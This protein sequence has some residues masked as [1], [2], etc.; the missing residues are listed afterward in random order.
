[1]HADPDVGRKNFFQYGLLRRLVKIIYFHGVLGR[2]FVR[3]YRKDL[4]VCH[5]LRKGRPEEVVNEY[6]FV[7]LAL[8]IF[9][10]ELG[11]D[12]LRYLGVVSFGDSREAR[13]DGEPPLREVV[14]A[15]PS[16]EGEFY[17]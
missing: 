14:E 8:H 7:G 16:E 2:L 10:D 4:L 11:G 5:H 1:L 9:R 3:F 6:Y 15:P 17:V 13:R 12:T